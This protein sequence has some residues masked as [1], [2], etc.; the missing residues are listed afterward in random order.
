MK[1]DK[2]VEVLEILGVRTKSWTTIVAKE[3]TAHVFS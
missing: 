1:G 2:V 3:E